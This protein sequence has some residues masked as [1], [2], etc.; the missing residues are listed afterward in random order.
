MSNS[1]WQRPR[2]TLHYAQTLDGRIATRTGSSQWISGSG[3]LRLAHELRAANDAVMVGVG[4]VCA[5]NPKLTV[6]HAEG[7]SPIRVIVDSRL[8]VPLSAQ[9]LTDGESPTIVAVTEAAA[10]EN[11]R[12]VAGLGAEVVLIG[13]DSDGLVDIPQLLSCLSGRGIETLLVEGGSRLLTSM[14]GSGTVDRVVVCI[15]PKIIG[16]GLNAVGSLSIDELSQ[17]L[18]FNP[19]SFTPLEGDVIFDGLVDQAG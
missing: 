17:A 12:A 19:S 1:D 10:P 6:R 7:T 14:L 18:T 2:V 16:E 11:M 15:A 9:V 13:S 4:T 5:D 3:S 8:R